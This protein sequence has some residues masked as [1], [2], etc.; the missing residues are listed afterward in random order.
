MSFSFLYRLR[1]SLVALSA[2]LSTTVWAQGIT[3][4][5]GKWEAVL[6]QSRAENKLVYVD[7]YTTWC[8]PCRMMAQQIFPNRKAGKVFN[9]Y[10]VNYKIDAEKG[11]GI[12]IA[13]TY[14]IRGYPTGLFVNPDGQL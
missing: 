4:F 6:A 12:K 7:V 10:F 3:F 2:L 5:E 9:G 1:L 11:E 8:G 14:G 13:S